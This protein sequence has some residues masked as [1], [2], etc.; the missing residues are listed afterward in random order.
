MKLS[1]KVLAPAFLVVLMI[2]GTVSFL[3]PP[4]PVGGKDWPL[5]PEDYPIGNLT[6]NL[7][8]TNV[9]LLG[10]QPIPSLGPGLD[11]PWGSQAFYYIGAYKNDTLMAFVIAQLPSPRE[12]ARFAALVMEHLKE[13]VPED[14]I[15]YL[16]GADGGYMDINEFNRTVQVWYGRG[17]LFLIQV[18]AD[19]ATAEEAIR[20]FKEAIVRAYSG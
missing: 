15:R 6:A 9:D 10:G 8:L 3:T 4:T 7:N 16:A 2:L 5:P 19:R 14:K 1:V 12:A 13:E 17:W 11:F 20:E 18:N